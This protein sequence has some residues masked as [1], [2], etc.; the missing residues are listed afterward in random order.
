[1]CVCSCVCVRVCVQMQGL[2]AGA[3][4]YIVKPFAPK[5]LEARVRSLLRRC[6]ILQHTAAHCNTLQHTATPCTTLQHPALQARVRSLFGSQ[7]CAMT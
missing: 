7:L 4:D 3:D 5:E 2:D 1:M 6:T